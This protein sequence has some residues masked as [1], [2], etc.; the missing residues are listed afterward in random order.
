MGQTSDNRRWE[1]PGVDE[2]PEIEQ[3]DALNRNE[4]FVC[5]SDGRAL[6]LTVDQLLRADHRVLQDEDDSKEE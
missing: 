2:M 4:V 3:A 6:V 5:L 1:N